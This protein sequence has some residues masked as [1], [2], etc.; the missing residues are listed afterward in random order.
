VTMGFTKNVLNPL[1]KNDEN[2]YDIK[3]YDNGVE[4]GGAKQASIKVTPV[5][6]LPPS[7]HSPPSK[8]VMHAPASPRGA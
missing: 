8:G 3:S 1:I 6:S 2:I 4:E 7:L 5:L